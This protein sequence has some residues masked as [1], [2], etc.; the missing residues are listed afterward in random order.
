MAF[1][2]KEELRTGVDTIDAQH[3]EL[4]ARINKLLDACNRLR[5]N[6]DIGNYLA[7]LEEYVELHFAAEEQEM[8]THSYPGFAAHAGEHAEF[9]QRV[10]DLCR[11]YEQQGVNISVLLKTISSS[12]EWL[13]SHI[14]KTDKEMASF[15]VQARKPG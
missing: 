8:R 1:E 9:R 6:G 15:L 5:E 14:M 7:F 10:K 11:Q 13:V 4:F 3:K 2:W 12:G